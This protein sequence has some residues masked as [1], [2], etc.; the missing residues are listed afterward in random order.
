MDVV[1]KDI[2]PLCYLPNDEI[3][4]YSRGYILCG[5]HNGR[6]FKVDN[7][8]K[9]KIVEKSKLLSRI[10]RA[11][12]RSAIAISDNKICLSIGNRIR[13]LD[14]SNG[15]LSRGYTCPNNCRPLNFTFVKSI[16]GLDDGIYW[17][18]Y[19]HNPSKK[20]VSIYK[21]VGRDIWL[22][23]YE[24]KE[25]LI[26]H[27][28]N[29][30]AD[31]Y[32]NC[33]WIF[34][35]DFGEASAIWKVTD[36]FKNIERIAFNSQKFRGCVAFATEDGLLY[37]TDTPFENN[38]IYKFDTNTYELNIL[39]SI[40]GSCIY[41]CKWKDE[42][43]FSTTVEGDGRGLSIFDFLFSVK[44]GAGIKDDY[45]HLYVGDCKNGFKEIYKERKDIYPFYLCQFG[46]FKFPSGNN[47]NDELLFQ[48]V[49]T[50]ENDQSLLSIHR[51]VIHE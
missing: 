47:N 25:G 41:G 24:F 28:H 27:V 45:V 37:A 11:G 5:L 44:R 30:V 14:L 31:P 32:R 13:E 8:I 1:S 9:Y 12:I 36:N 29:I 16:K 39:A 21:R 4:C 3:I 22:P 51:K 43:V 38:Y 40:A 26:N 7:S 46:V 48:P 33:L 20:A 49:A 15:I 42:Y 50:C 10:C 6:K 34:T 18:G 17:G 2:S 19:L 23:V 35:G